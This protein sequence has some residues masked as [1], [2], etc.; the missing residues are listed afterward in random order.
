MQLNFVYALAE[1]QVTDSCLIVGP[2]EKR[3]GWQ[4]MSEGLGE[5]DSTNVRKKRQWI[6]GLG[7]LTTSQVD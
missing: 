1:L 2:V 4:G 3:K 6:L 7:G 5:G